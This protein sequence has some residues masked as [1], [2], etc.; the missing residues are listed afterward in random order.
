LS[1]LQEEAENVKQRRATLKGSLF[2]RRS[3]VFSAEHSE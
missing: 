3:M 1:V 2:E